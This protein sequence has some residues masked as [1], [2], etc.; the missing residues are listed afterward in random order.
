M[1]RL[2]ICLVAGHP[3]GQEEETVSPATAWWVG[4]LTGLMLGS[5]LVIAAVSLQV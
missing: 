3:E 4:L 5:G 2:R 1:G